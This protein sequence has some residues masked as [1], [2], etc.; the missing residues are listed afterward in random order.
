MSNASRR[1]GPAHLGAQ[2]P[3]QP[4]AGAVP[5]AAPSASRT[6]P[7]TGALRRAM[8]ALRHVVPGLHWDARPSSAGR[9]SSYLNP[10]TCW[11]GG[12]LRRLHTTV[13]L[14]LLVVLASAA[15][16][17]LSFV[18]VQPPDPSRIGHSVRAINDVG[19]EA[20]DKR[21][22]CVEWAPGVLGPDRRH[23]QCRYRRRS[24]R[25]LGCSTSCAP[26]DPGRPRG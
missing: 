22:A 17:Q 1:V 2:T 13:A 26:G 23:H 19:T 10:L 24:D 20:T 15:G 5:H 9:S 14:V 21:R 3:E 4:F 12:H 7:R 11:Q 16:A 6:A 18:T 25:E 8:L